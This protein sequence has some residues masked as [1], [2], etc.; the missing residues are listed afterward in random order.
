M[1]K[2][3]P[4]EA[5]RYKEI[6]DTIRKE[7][8]NV[9]VGQQNIIT[10]LIR[11][12]IANGHVIVEGVPG[13]AKTL[14]VRAL[15][16]ATGLKFQRIQFTIDLLPS[17]IVGITTY[18]RGKGFITIKGPIFTNFLMADEINRASPKT[19]SALLEAM[20]EKQVTI[21]KVTYHLDLPFLVMA[22]TNPIES[23]GVYN[24]PE[25]QID[26][27]LFKLIMDFPKPQEE[28]EILST[29]ITLRRFEDFQVKPL[30]SPD[31]I[32]KI[33]EVAKRVYIS[34]EIEDYIVRL[35]TATRPPHNKK[36][37]LGKYVD[38]GAS[39]RASIGLFIAAK[40]DALIDGN[41]Y[42][43]PQNVKNIAHDVMRHRI[44]LNYEGQA[45]GIKTDAIINELL[46]S[47]PIP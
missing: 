34:K 24:L 25:A 9:V 16:E 22:T 2:V 45:E 6:F 4:A 1:S 10:G 8:A 20:Q 31:K 46:D 40:A 30:L 42:V 19:Q 3:S 13:I 21:S 5:K 18:S 29:N 14:V 11:A 15:A 23:A 26:R 39:P 38:Y 44:L 35:V 41:H 7:I 33:Q 47:V 12:L 37:K 28:Q 43:T 32:I 36:F 27:F 17:D